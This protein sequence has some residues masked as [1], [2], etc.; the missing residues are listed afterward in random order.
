MNDAAWPTADAPE[1]VI[2]FYDEDAGFFPSSATALHA[3]IKQVIEHESCTLQHL[4]YIFCS[5][6]YLHEINLK[7]LQHDTYTDIITFPYADPPAIHSDAFISVERVRENAE[8]LRLPFEEELRRVMIHGL[9]HL[10]GYPDK[11]EEEARRM[12]QKEEEALSL[13]ERHHTRP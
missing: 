11:T 4:N 8:Q 13:F 5:D 3:W 7:Y 12:R 2:E 6:A 9:L 10:C 1:G